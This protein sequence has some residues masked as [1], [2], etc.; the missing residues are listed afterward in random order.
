MANST[1]KKGDQPSEDVDED[2]SQRGYYYDDAHG[3]QNYEPDE[4]DETREDDADDSAREE[5]DTHRRSSDI[6]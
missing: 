5:N 3:Y 2:V 1:K 6:V 4:D